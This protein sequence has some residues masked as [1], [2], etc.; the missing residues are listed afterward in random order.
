MIRTTTKTVI[1]TLP[2]RLSG[3]E[4]IQPAGSYE[5]ATDEELVE[6][7]SFLAYRR[8][9]TLITL[10]LEGNHQL[11]RVEPAELEALLLSDRQVNTMLDSQER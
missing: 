5:V 11:L 10:G 4:E 9:A 8:I 2:F 6:D 7:V 3:L 1:F